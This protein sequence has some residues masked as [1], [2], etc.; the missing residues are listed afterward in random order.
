MFT[1]TGAGLCEPI[2]PF[3]YWCLPPKPEPKPELPVPPQDTPEPPLSV[4]CEGYDCQIVPSDD[5]P[6]ILSMR[7]DWDDWQK[8]IDPAD[9]MI[10]DATG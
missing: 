4:I 8:V 9:L 1:N 5:Y 2:Y 6:V 10:P 7:D 3:R